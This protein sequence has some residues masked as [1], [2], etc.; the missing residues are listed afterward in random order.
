MKE[1]LKL[2]KDEWL[3]KSCNNNPV[4]LLKYLDVETYESVGDSVM[5]AIL[6]VGMG[7]PDGSQ[8]I[9]QFKELSCDEGRGLTSTIVISSQTYT[10]FM[11]CHI[12]YF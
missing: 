9:Q 2:L 7:K 11:L 4:E 12:M 8:R 3:C 5:K 1:C 6:R 10:F